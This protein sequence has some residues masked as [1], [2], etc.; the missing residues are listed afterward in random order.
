MH[1]DLTVTRDLSMKVSGHADRLKDLQEALESLHAHDV[2]SYAL[3]VLVEAMDSEVRSLAQ[4]L[5][6][7]TAGRF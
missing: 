6:P 4:H 2:G 3:E 5:E 1:I 7:I